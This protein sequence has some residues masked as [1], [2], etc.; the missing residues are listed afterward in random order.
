MR[1]KKNWTFKLRTAKKQHD[2]YLA[3][4]AKEFREGKRRRR[5]NADMV[6]VAAARTRKRGR[7]PKPSRAA[8]LSL[9]LK[10]PQHLSL[11]DNGD[12]TLAYCKEVRKRA[13]KPNAQV[14]L[15]FD[16]VET[17]TTDALLLIR[18]IIDECGRT[19]SAR[20]P[21]AFRGNLPRVESVATEFKASGFF[22]GISRPPKNLPEP[23]GTFFKASKTIVHADVAADLSK[24]AL[25]HAQ[26]GQDHAI[27]SYRNLVELMNNTHEHAR[28]VEDSSRT[29]RPQPSSRWFASVYCRE[30]VAYFNFL[31]FGIGIMGSAPVRRAGLKLQRLLGFPISNTHLLAEVFSGK[32]GSS[33]GK[34]GRGRGLPGMRLD[35]Q[36]S[37]L[38]QLRVLTSNVT[39]TIADLEFLTI[40][41]SFRGTAFHWQAKYEG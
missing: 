4:R 30:G 37:R 11:F 36:E 40:K 23:A 27:T 14:Y 2:E 3:A 34:P 39:G 6:A 25:H 32:A 5:R 9:P 26:I 18:A 16:G 15:D 10:A 24:F 20:H 19:G 17:F 28:P 41:G 8:R 22:K 7:T 35:A 1:K 33:T 21:A 12:E 38:S 13:S 29:R 31:D